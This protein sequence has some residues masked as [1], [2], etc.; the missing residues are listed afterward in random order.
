MVQGFHNGFKAN[1]GTTLCAQVQPNGRTDVLIHREERVAPKVSL[2]QSFGG[3][4]RLRKVVPTSPMRGT[5]ETQMTNEKGAAT[6]EAD[7]LLLA[8]QLLSPLAIIDSS[9]Q[10]MINSAEAMTPEDV[11]ARALRIRNATTRLSALA[12]GLMNRARVSGEQVLD[13]QEFVW[14][15]L[16]SRAV[17]QIHCLHPSRQIN[18]QGADTSLRFKGDPLLLE[19]MLLILLCNAAKYSS[20]E[21]AIKIIAQVSMDHV[22]ILIRDQGIGIPEE[23]LPHIFKPF[24]RSQNATSLNG[25]GLGLSLADRIARMHGGVIQVESQAGHGSTFTVVLPAA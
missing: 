21:S 19:Q 16:I 18:I 2:P 9:A 12:H 5:E 17:D 15:N 13:R 24:F 10:R 11:K 14:A 7:L 22:S 20:T 6:F 3:T 23:D 8:H 4:P 25:T 1:H